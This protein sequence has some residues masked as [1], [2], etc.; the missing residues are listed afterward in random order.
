M[1]ALATGSAVIAAVFFLST[2]AF[3][4]PA[5]AGI[6]KDSS[7]AI[8]PGVNV[9]AASPVLIEKSRTVVT[10]GTGQYRI[11]DLKPGTYTVTFTLSGFA[12]IKREGIELTGAGVTTINA[13]MRVGAVSETVTVTGE[14]PVVDIQT[15]TKREVVLS[16]EVLAAVPASRTYGN[17][18]ATGARRPVVDARRELHPVD[19]RDRHEF[20]LHVARRTR[21]RRHD[22][23]RRHE[24]R[25]GV[26]RR[27]RREL[28][29]RF[30]ERAGGPGDGRRRHG[31]ERPRRA[32][33]QHH[34]Q[35]R[36]QHVQRHRVRQH[37]GQVVAGE[38]PRRQLRSFG[39]TE[40]PGLIKN[41]D[42]NF[43]LGG[44]I[45]QRPAVVLQQRA[46]LRARTRTFPALYANTNAG[47]AAQVELREG[48]EREG[49]VGGR[50]EDRSD[51]PDRPGHAEEQGG[52]LLRLPGELHRV[53][54][55]QHGRAVPRP[56]RRLDRARHV[57]DD[58]PPESGN[59]WADREK[60][61]QATWSS[62]VTSTPA[63]R[64][65][66]LVVQQ[67]VGR[68][69]SGR[70]ADGSR[71]RDRAEHRG[72]RADRRTSPIAAGRRRRPTTSST[73]SG[74]R[75]CA[76][77]TGAHSFKVGYQ[78]AYQVYGRSR[79]STTS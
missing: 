41:W 61:T 37:G 5:V 57:G 38:Q 33:V 26:R 34:S 22:P 64:G 78:A 21:Q 45:K 19:D 9:E 27:R 24:R 15:S 32:G 73:T 60:I 23:D 28:R 53:G 63:V 30:R 40:P 3:S 58:R 43:A 77:V 7:G 51:P 2:P 56:R 31:R 55:R 14:T 35:D 10:D 1:R 71:R 13:D 59:M 36:R 25:V 75:R 70:V 18:L 44:P 76:Y 17:I 68:L 79:T 16:N 6:V 52:V 42:T 72:R 4:Q 66:L 50:Q 67:Q 46:Q 20:L 69:H 8:L 49:A 29:L 39:I 54:A 74:A 62:P 12:T 47:D 65:R 48:S 11:V